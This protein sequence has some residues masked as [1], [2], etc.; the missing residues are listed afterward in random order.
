[1]RRSDCKLWRGHRP[2][3]SGGAIKQKPISLALGRYRAVCSEQIQP[4]PTFIAI[5]AKAQRT[6]VF[7]L[8]RRSHGVRVSL[9]LLD[10][11]SRNKKRLLVLER[12]LRFVTTS[13]TGRRRSENANA[14]LN[15]ANVA[16]VT[17]T[18]TRGRQPSNNNT[19]LLRRAARY[20]LIRSN[21]VRHD[22]SSYG[23]RL[24]LFVPDGAVLKLYSPE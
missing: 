3:R 16:A 8:Q 11:V 23:E 21:S 18:P 17:T 4:E 13:S 12:I 5:T 20:Q 2:E 15:F 6:V 7:I 10:S 19:N 22:S 9:N 24:F 14:A 1:M